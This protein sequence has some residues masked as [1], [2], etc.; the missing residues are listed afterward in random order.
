MTTLT[1]KPLTFENINSN[2]CM[3][4]LK[5]KPNKQ[6]N[7]YPKKDGLCNFCYKRSLDHTLTLVTECYTVKMKKKQTSVKTRD[8]KQILIKI[9][10]IKPETYNKSVVNIKNLKSTLSFYKIKYRS[11]EKKEQLFL[12][13]EKFLLPLEKYMVNELK[14]ITIQSIVKKYLKNKWVRLRGPGFL[15]RKK[16]V[17]ETDFYTCENILDISDKHFFSYKNKDTIYG[18]DI[19]SFKKLLDFK[20]KNP[21]DMHD[22]PEKVLKDFGELYKNM[23]KNIDSLYEPLKLT[24]E[25]QFDQDLLRVFDIYDNLKYYTDVDW[26]KKLN[27]IGL[28]RLYMEVQDIWRFRAGLNNITRNNIVPGANIFLLRKYE[29]YKLN[30]NQL[31]YTLLNEMETIATRGVTQSDKVL[32][33]L[34]MITALVIVSPRARL[35]YPDLYQTPAF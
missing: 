13:L 14:I 20:M 5:M 26:F 34:F 18:F 16:C 7:K 31:R 28:R 8:D 19:R 22:I 32:G 33:A 3:G 17:N 35:A 23:S 6:C 15:D 25:Q 30:L 21:Y 9:N 2:K 27:I 12:K 4:R 24:K 11:N 1:Y 29:L 10:D